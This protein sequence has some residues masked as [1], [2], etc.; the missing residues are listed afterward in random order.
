TAGS[1]LTTIVVSGFPTGSIPFTLSFAG[2]DLANTSITDNR[3]VDGTVTVTFLNA[4]TT[5][6]AGSFNV[7]P[8]ADSD[9]DLGLLTATVPAANDVDPSVTDTDADQT[10]VRVDAIAD[11]DDGDGEKLGVT[12]T[13]I[14]DGV[15]GNSTFQAGE[16][17]K[18]NINATFDDYKDGSET[19]TLTVD[20][21]A[22]FTFNLADVGTLPAGVTLNGASTTTHLI[23]DIDSQNPGGVGSLSL[24]I[25]ATYNGGQ[26]N[27][28]SGNFTATV[29]A[30][31]TP[32]DKECDETNNKA[33][34]SDTEATTIAS[35]PTTN[36]SLNTEGDT[37]FVCVPEDSTGVA[38]PVSASTTAGSHLT[39]IVISGF[40]TGSIPFTLNFAGLDLANTSIT[41]NRA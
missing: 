8:A 9:V 41:D 17:G 34:Q 1:H 15:D 30:V 25:P 11:G 23:F 19:H 39:T 22:G 26:A 18:V 7:I 10:Y 5:N 3:A 16:T 24:S 31:E 29:N 12:I 35:A 13:S 33:T 2:L 37:D 6:F 32:T 4:T 21:P 28:A 38:V 14:V 40:P 20:A 27:G 36:V